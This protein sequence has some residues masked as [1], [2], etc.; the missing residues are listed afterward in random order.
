[1]TNQL[2][3]ALLELFEEFGGTTVEEWKKASYIVGRDASL[4][5]QF[6]RF[7]ASLSLFTSFNSSR[8]YGSLELTICCNPRQS[9]LLLPSSTEA[10]NIYS[11][12][13]PVRKSCLHRRYADLIRLSHY[14]I[15]TLIVI[16][17]SNRQSLLYDPIVFPCVDEV[18]NGKQRAI[19]VRNI[20]ANTTVYLASFYTPDDA[21][22]LRSLITAAGGS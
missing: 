18:H 2:S 6:V 1:L 7:F 13:S 19:N 4:Q 16:S 3:A 10:I 21:C 12:P 5:F 8:S 17:L 20:L 11:L 15:F 9:L 22:Y 14:L